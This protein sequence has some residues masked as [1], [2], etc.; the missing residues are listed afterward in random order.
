VSRPAQ[1][2]LVS[3]AAWGLLVVYVYAT[4]TGKPWDSL[5]EPT[6][7]EQTLIESTTP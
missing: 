4:V 7:H 6:Y 1:V 5:F 2:I 3:L